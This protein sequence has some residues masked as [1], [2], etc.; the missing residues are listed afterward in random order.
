MEA[1]EDIEKSM[2]KKCQEQSVESKIKKYLKEI[3]KLINYDIYIVFQFN[4]NKNV[5]IAKNYYVKDN[6]DSNS[7]IPHSIFFQKNP[8]YLFNDLVEKE[9]IIE[10][11]HEDDTRSLFKG[12]K[13]GIYVPIFSIE[14]L[15]LIG[16]IYFGTFENT[17]KGLKLLS[18]KD[19]VYEIISNISYTLEFSFI[20]T[21]VIKNMTN[22]IQVLL[23]ILNQKDNT[24]F[25]HS[26]NVAN[27]CK[28][29][30]LELNLDES[31]IIKLYIAGLLHDVGKTYIDDSIINK[32]GKLTDE[33]YEKVKTHSL[34]S[35]NIA[36]KVLIEYPD[37]YGIPKV[38]KYH[39]ERYD[40][41]GYPR[42]LSGDEVPFYS[43][44]LSISDA[45]DAML[46][47]RP[48]KKGYS[49]EKVIY[50]L[51]MDK[52][53]QFH[54]KLVDLMINILTKVESEYNNVL[55]N[56]FNFCYLIINCDVNVYV[57]EGVISK[58]MGYYTF[59]PNNEMEI[60]NI[61][62]KK[63]M[64][65]EIVIKD[66]KKVLNYKIKIE[67]MEN[68]DFYISS[69]ELTDYPSS[70][71]LLWNLE[72]IL[73]T[74]NKKQKINITQIG[75]THL[76]FSSY[77]DIN[78]NEFINKPL[79]IDILFSDYIVDVSGIII[80]TYKIGLRQYCDFKYMEIPDFKR[81]KIFRQL[82]KKQIEIR[83][84]VN[85]VSNFN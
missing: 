1:I 85:E 82:F 84:L 15:R 68:N 47:D 2:F 49:V 66:S 45:V 3:D 5:A 26:C 19:E 40:G 22:T 50:R 78:F 54:P 61:D 28:E 33:E 20:K 83:K 46:S 71:N 29:L 44:I 31:E 51:Q 62:L 9:E 12:I 35:Y 70:F 41:N 57:Y 65:A 25:S 21:N 76:R 42:G 24:L 72:G 60:S 39:H 11:N 37:L 4:M 77:E 74:N 7:E 58:Y 34:F 56:H 6:N 32:R 63:I 52:G 27:W 79:R 73:F 16:C 14:D 38:I 55:D 81:D 43:Y 18:K 75:G 48:Y 59:N 8:K 30:G 36:R 23:M 69:I 17:T 64:S 13:R 67:D 10:Y 80:K 53:K